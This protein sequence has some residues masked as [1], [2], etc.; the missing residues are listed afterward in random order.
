M[1]QISVV[2]LGTARAWYER[3]M[4]ALHD[5]GRWKWLPT[6][7]LENYHFAN[8]ETPMPNMEKENYKQLLRSKD[9]P[10]KDGTGIQFVFQ[11]IL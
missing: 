4:Q 1:F 7:V 9:E 11:K 5:Q 6:R 10:A 2:A 8:G 3:E